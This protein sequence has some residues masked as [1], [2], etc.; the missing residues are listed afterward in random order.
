MMG[1][2]NALLASGQIR[3]NGSKTKGR[4]YYVSGT[5]PYEG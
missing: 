5:K 3:T 4:L 1:M 2:L